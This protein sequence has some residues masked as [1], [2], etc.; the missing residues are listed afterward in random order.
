LIRSDKGRKIGISLPKFT[1]YPLPATRYPLPATR[2]P[3]SSPFALIGSA[4]EF[5]GKQPALKHVGVWLVFLPLAGIQVLLR[6]L[7]EDPTTGDGRV[8]LAM[9]LAILLLSL[10]MLW[11]DACVL[12][13][14]KRLLSSNAGRTR[15]SFR[16][17][18]AQA[19]GFV[20][21]L[22]ITDILRTGMTILWSLLL[23]IPGVIYS[24]RTVFAAIVI[25]AEGKAYRPALRRS[26]D[27]VRGR[28]FAAFLS[29]LG[30]SITLFLPIQALSLAA[31]LM[32]EDM[33][34]GYGVAADVIVSACHSVS[35]VVHGLAMIL[36]YGEL[37]E[38]AAQ[39]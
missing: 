19:R 36:L 28:T 20:L 2:Y 4:W 23:V 27:V 9:A 32:I 18:R 26:M 22:L 7:P 10:L 5:A 21:P 1:R 39:D 3:L 38:A 34:P 11:G 15:T 24:I 33:H 12:V 30:L 25:V 31:E 14:G 13:V 16:A 8:L 6:F 35:I 37:V 17:V 29:L